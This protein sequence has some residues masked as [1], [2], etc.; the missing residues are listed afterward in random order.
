MLNPSSDNFSQPGLAPTRKLWVSGMTHF[1]INRNLEIQFQI[2]NRPNLGAGLGW[3]WSPVTR[4][5]A[6][7]RKSTFQ[8]L[9]NCLQANCVWGLYL[10]SFKKTGMEG[11]LV[12]MKQVRKAKPW[13]TADPLL[14]SS[15]PNLQRHL[16]TFIISGRL[17]WYCLSVP[18]WTPRKQVHDL[19]NASFNKTHFGF[20]VDI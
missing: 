5:N 9:T 11:S 19:L 1:L 13:Q 3:W 20:Q 12:W 4:V 10:V 6:L 7:S 17:P 14:N 15:G 8:F 18:V 2:L 16:L